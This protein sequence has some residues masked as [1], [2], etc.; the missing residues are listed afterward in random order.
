MEI[1]NEKVQLHIEK[2]KK[3]N[4]ISFNFLLDTF[5]NDVYRYQLSKIKNDNDAEDITIRTFSK[6]FD[7][8]HTFNTTYKF[9]TWLIAIS[10]NVYIDFLRKKNSR[11]LLDTSK[12]QEEAASRII[13]NEPSAESKIITE[14]NLAKL[15]RDIKKLKPKYQEV[16]HLRFFQE[17][18]YKEISDKT[19]EPINNVKIKLLRAKKLLAEIIKKP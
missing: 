7:K 12:E 18:S 10:K 11:I 17:L 13:D 8:I 4:Q 14:Q 16:I 2:A 1:Q 19:G 9:K 6:A 5:W 3:G 15:L